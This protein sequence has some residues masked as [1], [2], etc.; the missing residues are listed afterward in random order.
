MTGS[1]KVAVASCYDKKNYGSV[2]QA[3]ATHHV[4]DRLGCEVLTLDKSGLSGAIAQGRRSYYREHAADLSLYKAKLGFALHRIRQKANRDFGAKMKERGAAFDRFVADRFAF[5]RKVNSFEDL[6]DYCRQFDDVVVGSDQLWLPVNI[7]GNYFT[8]SFVEP[9]TKKISYATSFGVSSLSEK[10]LERVGGFLSSF[11][12]LSVRE[13]TGAQLV[14]EATGRSSAVVCDPTMLMT[15]DEWNKVADR[16]Y[17][18]PEGGYIFCYFLGKNLWNRECAEKLALSCGCPIVAM[19]HLDEYVKYD[20][21][22]ADVYPY[23]AGP[24]AW[25]GLLAGAKY[26]CTDSFHGTVF[27]SLFNRPFFTFRRH[28]NVGQQS[29]NSRLDT[30][31]H[32]LGLMDRLYETR[33]AFEAACDHGIDFVEVNRRI[34]AYRR[35]SESYLRKALGV[36][37]DSAANDESRDAES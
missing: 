22:Y 32:E 15:R 23:D 33:E 17:P 36:G 27:A 13:T 12:S 2:L 31:L 14:K 34:D 25:I 29:T 28:E 10:E 9:P 26:V 7:S 37:N 35:G 8:L 5:S 19:A 6:T 3:Y 30:L 21:R 11:D 16:D 1:P 24:D 20:D 4:I 18:R